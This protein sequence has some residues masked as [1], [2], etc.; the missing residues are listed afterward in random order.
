MHPILICTQMVTNGIE[1]SWEMLVTWFGSSLLTPI[2]ALLA[3][4]I[5]DDKGPGLNR[6]GALYAR[7]GGLQVV[8][9]KVSSRT[10][11]MATD[12]KIRRQTTGK[13]SPRIMIT[14]LLSAFPFC[15]TAV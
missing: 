9:V 8:P 1:I 11:L 2:T 7:N 10:S 3:K 12:V 6:V 4:T 15:S 5:Q 13:I 14:D